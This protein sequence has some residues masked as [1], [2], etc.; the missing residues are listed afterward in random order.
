MK[1]YEDIK[2]LVECLDIPNMV[3]KGFK[4]KQLRLIKEEKKRGLAG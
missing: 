2:R 4:A 1:K 3:I